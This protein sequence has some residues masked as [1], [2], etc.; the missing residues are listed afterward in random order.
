MRAKGNEGVAGLV[1]KSVG[2]IGYVG[3]EF[4]RRLGLDTALLENK[5]GQYVRASEQTCSKALAIADIPDNFRAFIPDPKGADSYPIVT[6][7]WILLRKGYKDPQTASEL[8]DLFTWCLQD[9][10]HYASQLGYVQIPTPLAQR[11]VAALDSLS[12]KP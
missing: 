9:G 1:E 8:R 3:F 6:L 5:D 10:Q 4:A 11:A 7:S 2:S 12:A